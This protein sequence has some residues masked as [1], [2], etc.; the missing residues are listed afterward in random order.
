MLAC[1]PLVCQYIYSR[2]FRTRSSMESSDDVSQN[3]ECDMKSVSDN[4]NVVPRSLTRSLENSTHWLTISFKAVN[5]AQVRWRGS[6]D[7]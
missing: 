1:I 4:I 3:L 5:Y 2:N 6:A 7:S